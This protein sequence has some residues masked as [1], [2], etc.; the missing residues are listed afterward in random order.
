MSKSILDLLPI[1]DQEISQ[2]NRARDLDSVKKIG[3]LTIE[4]LGQH[5]LLPKVR[6]S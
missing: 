3:H 1:V 4:L 6:K 2:Q 5:A